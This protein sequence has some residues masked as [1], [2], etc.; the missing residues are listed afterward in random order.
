MRGDELDGPGAD[1]R[2]QEAPPLYANAMQ[3]H[4]GVFDVVLD[5]GFQLGDRPGVPPE[6]V[7]RIATSWEHIAAMTKALSAMLDQYQQRLGPL[8]DVERARVDV[9]EKG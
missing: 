3:A 4:A 5:F 1:K 9:D 8:P 6:S 7:A 2:L